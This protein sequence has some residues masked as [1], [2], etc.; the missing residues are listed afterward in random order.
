MPTRPENNGPI[1]TSA[2]SPRETTFGGGSGGNDERFYSLYSAVP[3]LSVGP[4]G[5]HAQGADEYVK[6]GSLVETAQ[7][8]AL[9]VV[10]WCGVEESATSQV[11]IRDI[12]RN[13]G[14]KSS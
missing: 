3:C 9:T 10:D 1:P 7:V 11:P 2:P 12:T 5:E 8:L 13:V 4:R 6:I 14:T